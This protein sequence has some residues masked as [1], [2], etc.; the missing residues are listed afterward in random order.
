MRKELI[1]FLIESKNMDEYELSYAVDSIVDMTESGEI[2]VHEANGVLDR[3]I[4]DLDHERPKPK[5]SKLKAKIANAKATIKKN[6]KKIILGTIGAATAIG[7]A[8]KLNQLGQN[9]RELRNKINELD[10]EKN[11]MTG[12]LQNEINNL[13]NKISDDEENK[14][15][16]TKYA[17]DMKNLA[18]RRG[19]IILQ[20]EKEKK[21]IQDEMNHYKTELQKQVNRINRY[22]DTLRKQREKI[23]KLRRYQKQSHTSS[24]NA[25]EN[26]SAGQ[27]I[28][29]GIDLDALAKNM[30]GNGIK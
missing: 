16:V 25:N 28:L 9:N 19:D 14:K 8:V 23:N 11:K 2:M 4:T 30:M 12:N 26:Q 27:K 29:N 18:H 15:K 1:T 21:Q 3:L 6:K 10:A 5:K 17:N 24:P 7:G 20:S 22:E 13:K